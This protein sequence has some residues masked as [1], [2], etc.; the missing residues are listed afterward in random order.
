MVNI[1]CHVVATVTRFFFFFLISNKNIL[2][3][4]GG[5]TRV[6]MK[7]TSRTKTNQVHKVQKSMKSW[8][9]EKERKPNI[10][11]QSRRVLRKKSLRSETN[12]SKSS[13]CQLFLSLQIH[14]IKQFCT[15]IQIVGACLDNKKSSL[16][17]RHS[18]FI[19]HHSSLITYHSSLI[20]SHS[21]GNIIFTF[22]TQFFH[23]IHGSYTCQ[24]VQCFFFFLFFS[25]QLTEANII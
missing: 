8:I 1:Y 16:N 9:G 15:A 4:R 24:P 11:T 10:V 7:Y 17:F 6:C 21:F 5:V 3:R 23:T 20:F 18:I 12:L 19:T 2:K 22:I 14:H 25:T 13:K